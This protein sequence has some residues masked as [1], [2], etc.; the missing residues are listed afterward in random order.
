[1]KL[2][3]PFVIWIVCSYVYVAEISPLEKY[4]VLTLSKRIYSKTVIQK[5]FVDTSDYSFEYLCN[6]AHILRLID[7][8]RNVLF[9]ELKKMSNAFH[10]DRVGSSPHDDSKIIFIV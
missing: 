6:F 3:S 1:M 5:K 9:I 4:F 10:N 7:T 8:H 2:H